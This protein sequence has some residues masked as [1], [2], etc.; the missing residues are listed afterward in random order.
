M[1]VEESLQHLVT[2]IFRKQEFYIERE[3]TRFVVEQVETAPEPQWKRTMKFR[4]ISPTTVSVPEMRNGKMSPTY[5]FHDDPRLSDCL[6]KNIANKYES[7]YGKQPDDCSF[8]CTLDEQFINDMQRK[9]K[10]MSKLITIKGGRIDQTQVRG[11]MCPVTIEGNPELIKLA[12]E[13]GLGEK[14]SLGFGMLDIA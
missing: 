6:K 8:H 14:G 5:L 3:E 7:L 1:P 12:Y 4:M 9:G 11:F 10:K 2:G 13:S